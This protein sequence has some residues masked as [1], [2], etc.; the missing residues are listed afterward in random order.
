MATQNLFF[1]RVFFYRKRSFWLHSLFFTAIVVG[2]KYMNNQSQRIMFNMITWAFLVGL[3]I[4]WILLHVFWSSNYNG[5]QLFSTFYGVIALWGGITGLYISKRCGGVRSH[6]GRSIFFFSLGLLFQEFGQIV[7]SYYIYF[8]QVDVLY[9]SMG[10]LGFF[11]SI[12]FYTFGI[13]YLG[14]A[15]GFFTSLRMY[16][17]NIW[18]YV[19]PSILFLFSYP[20][21]LQWYNLSDISP[22]A[23]A[24]G[25]G[26]LV[27]GAIYVSLSMMMYL[28]FREAQVK[29]IQVALFGIFLALTAQ[30]I[31]DYTF[32]FQVN[33]GVWSAGGINDMVYL[34]SYFFMTLGLMRLQRVF[35]DTKVVIGRN[36]ETRDYFSLTLFFGQSIII[37][38]KNCVRKI[39][40]FFDF[41]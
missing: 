18:A 27:G 23:V 38:V 33:D 7:Y 11:G 1:S 34:L 41:V 31:A 19:L 3:V 9:P 4:W 20:I 26:Y 17:H 36:G 25:I 12:P 13:Y 32:L 2:F 8:L 22:Y 5:L 30:Y 15:T 16:L 39:K 10:D 14:K 35:E 24:L 29:N 40:L 28:S 37:L 6:I 21:F